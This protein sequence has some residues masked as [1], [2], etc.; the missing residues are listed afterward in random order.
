MSNLEVVRANT[1][2][3]EGD[4]IILEGDK[5]DFHTWRCKIKSKKADG[6]DSVAVHIAA[7]V[8]LRTIS[9][10]IIH[11]PLHMPKSIVHSQDRN[12]Q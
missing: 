5:D 7:I 6:A 10:Q 11:G 2:S 12:K 4:L 3:V 1:A 8:I 9:V